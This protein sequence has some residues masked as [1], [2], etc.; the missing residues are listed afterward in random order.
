MTTRQD[1]SV[2]RR[3]ALAGLRAGGF[4]LALAARGVSAAAQEGT[5]PADEGAL[6][7]VVF[8]PLGFGTTE[9]VPAAPAQFALSRAVI[10]PGAGFSRQGD[11][12]ALLSLFYVES[13]ALTLQMDARSSHPRRYHH[14]RG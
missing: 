3:A 12:V 8:G 7:G 9:E 1:R 14:W 10:D 11:I 6:E 13:G 2:S 4:G 5:P